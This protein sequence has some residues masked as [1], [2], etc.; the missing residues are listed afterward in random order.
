MLFLTQSFKT[1][2]D[3]GVIT[4]THRGDGVPQSMA[5]PGSTHTYPSRNGDSSG[6]LFEQTQLR[7]ALSLN[8]GGWGYKTSLDSSPGLRLTSHDGRSRCGRGPP[9]STP[10]HLCSEM[11]RLHLPTP[12][13]LQL[14]LNLKLIHK[15]KLTLWLL[16]STFIQ[17]NHN[18][19]GQ[20]MLAQGSAVWEI[21]LARYTP[22]RAHGAWEPGGL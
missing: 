12:L 22:K 8:S 10:R 11:W 5:E 4:T 7:L 13:P 16:H 2:D 18:N 21:F 17:I 19:R 15:R 14:A 3:L 9:L 20:N 6:Q 1:P